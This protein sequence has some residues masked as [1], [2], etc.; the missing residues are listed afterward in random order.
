[1]DGEEGGKRQAAFERVKKA[2]LLASTSL[3]AEQLIDKLR[4]I[5]ATKTSCSERPRQVSAEKAKKSRKKAENALPLRPLLPPQLSTTTLV[6]LLLFP[7]A[8]F[9][10]LTLNLLLLL[11]S[12]IPV[13]PKSAKCSGGFEE[14]DL[15]CSTS[16]RGVERGIRA[17]G[18]VQRRRREKAAGVRG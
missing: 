12:A 1:M 3:A 4:R 8:R 13:P 16:R 6:L 9:L 11:L 5:R 10:N 14:A 2:S 15:R 18:S 7:T 17:E